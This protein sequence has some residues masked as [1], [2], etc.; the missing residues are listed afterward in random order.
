MTTTRHILVAGGG[1]AAIETI[2]ALKDLSDSFEI[3][4]LAPGEELTLP[5]YEVL[6]PFRDL[7]ERR[8]SLAAIA[9]DLGVNLRRGSLATV[10]PDW[11]RIK[12][13]SGVE[14]AYNSLVIATG[15]RRARSVPGAKTFRGAAD[16]GLLREFLSDS[17]RG[18]HRRVAFVVPGGVTWPLPVYELALHTAEWLADRRITS[19]P[20]TVVSAEPG[21]LAV[22][23]PDASAE[24]AGLLADNRIEFV[25]DYAI[26]YRGGTLETM[27]GTLDVDLA[28]AL[29]R[30][31][32]PLIAGL[33]HDD[34]AFL[35]VDEHG[36]VRGV[37]DVF[38]AGDVTTHP[39]KQGGLATQQAD[40]IAQQIAAESGIAIEPQPYEPDLH[41][42]LLAGRRQHALGAGAILG[43][44]KLRGR[45]LTPYLEQ[46]DRAHGPATRSTAPVP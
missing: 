34:D 41:A 35:P 6:S 23:G 24:V 4:L 19:I 46:L 10:H 21:P 27:A 3:E 29:P 13:L 31:H 22:F 40:A 44:H 5:P 25:R 36:R 38:A 12:T 18:V 33:P 39:I 7:Q 2:L 14:V 8:Y 15:A 9:D 17:G 20:L 43:D 26:R 37:G 45:Y 16:A 11:H 1:P 30:L 32:G 28:I 42:L